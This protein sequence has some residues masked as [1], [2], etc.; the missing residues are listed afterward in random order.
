MDTSSMACRQALLDR[1]RCGFLIRHEVVRI[2]A[3]AS[4]RFLLMSLRN[5]MQQVCADIPFRVAA[6]HFDPLCQP[7]YALKVPDWPQPVEP[8]S[9]S[10]FGRARNNCLSDL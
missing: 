8:E 2:H 7:R 5:R 3:E 4:K 9:Q 1:S 6:L 10:M